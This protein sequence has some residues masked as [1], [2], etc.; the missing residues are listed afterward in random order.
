MSNEQRKPLGKTI[1]ETT[2][3]TEFN[4]AVKAWE[5]SI[6]DILI[7]LSVARTSQGLVIYPQDA[8]EFINEFNKLITE[9]R[10]NV[11]HGT[12]VTGLYAKDMTKGE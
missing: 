3:I 1:P 12:M 9:A 7:G 10:A 4:E 5:R 8:V 11:E 6:E 2:G